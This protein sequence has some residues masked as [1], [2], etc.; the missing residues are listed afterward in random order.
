[1]VIFFLPAN[2]PEMAKIA[3]LL[4]VPASLFLFSYVWLPFRFKRNL[5]LNARFEFEP[6]HPAREVIPEELWSHIRETIACLNPY[7]FRIVGHFRKSGFVPGFIGFTT[8]METGNGTT[9]VKAMSTF[10]TNPRSGKGDTT[11]AFFTESA[12]GTEIVTA[13]NKILAGTP[14]SK[15][16]R[17]IALWMPA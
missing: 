9:V 5:W 10:V 12:D 17:R 15:T 4:S 1:A 13:N 3:A 6:F 14:H 16:K 8:L 7:V 11:L 2:W